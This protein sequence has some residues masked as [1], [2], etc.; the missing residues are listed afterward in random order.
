MTLLKRYLPYVLVLLICLPLVFI[1]IKGT[2]DWGDD[3]AQ[4]IMQA[5][6]IAEGNPHGATGYI[7]NEDAPFVGPR[8]FPPGF[9]L[10][11]APVYTT[12]GISIEGFT[13]LISVFLILLGIVSY[14]FFRKKFSSFTSLLL[15]LLLVWNPWILMFKTE[16]MSDI[17]FTFFFML[18]IVLYMS[19][20]PRSYSQSILIA[21]LAAFTISIRSIGIALALAA[22]SDLL[23][24]INA[25]RKIT[26]SVLKR[27]MIVQAAMILSMVAVWALINLLV[28][29]LPGGAI[30]SYQKVINTDGFF[31][32]LLVNLSYY[33]QV[34]QNFFVAQPDEAFLPVITRSFAL[35]LL[36][37]GL[38]MKMRTK[39]TFTELV[40]ISYILVLL[41]Y[42]YGSAGLRFLVP[43]LPLCLYYI[44]S[45]GSALTAML[46]LNTRIIAG[47]LAAFILYQY[48]DVDKKII[49]VRE[50]PIHGPYDNDA[51][52]AFEYIR[53]NTPGN[54][55]IV[56]N[57]PRALALYTDRRSLTNPE[58][59]AIEPMIQRFRE[60]G[61]GYYLVSEELTDSSLKALVS[62]STKAVK[63]WSNKEFSF[64]KAK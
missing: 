56:F 37:V 40:F 48:A 22:A 41:V 19:R 29:P 14:I 39:T 9:P 20:N 63:M 38:F 6:N 7:H 36:L 2:H 3:F 17:P 53:D 24:N 12:Q 8:A 27:T 52:E 33:L 55:V 28:F 26:S 46:K 64:Y 62:D 51:Q 15:L 58:G 42:P 4:Y 1:N 31:S 13:R 45:G 49:A 57:K 54:A 34:F 23:L 44:A 30:S 59:Q 10:L 25:Y 16:V 11:L 35:V 50:N 61:A 5:K 43:V 32:G 47:I 60:K 21:A 18:C